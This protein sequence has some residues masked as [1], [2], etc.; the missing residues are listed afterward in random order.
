MGAATIYEGPIKSQAQVLLII[1]LYNI[2]VS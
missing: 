2:P 1:Y